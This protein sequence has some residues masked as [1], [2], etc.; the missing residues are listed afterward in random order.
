VLRVAATP[1]V[2][3]AVLSPAVIG[4]RHRF[5]GVRCELSTFHT[6]KIVERLLLGEADIG[7]S[8][9]DP[10][11]AGIAAT[12]LAEH[13]V[14][15]VAPAGTWPQAELGLPLPVGALAGPMIGLAEGDPV[16][17]LVQAALAGH[18]VD[19]R[20]STVVQTHQLAFALVAAGH[21][22]ALLDPF[23]AAAMQSG[24]VQTR[25]CAPAMPVSLFLLTR[26]QATLSDPAAYLAQQVGA[27]ARCALG[28]LL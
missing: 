27:A 4:W 13:V 3:S 23:T 7:L 1:S 22:V 9:Q 20:C 2:A 5:P 6:E 12:V 17:A 16:G 28:R 10:R 19:P 11:R 15:T 24:L 26:D 14:M 18:G 8:L 21:G 25:Q